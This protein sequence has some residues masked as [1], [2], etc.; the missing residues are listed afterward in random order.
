MLPGEGQAQQGDV[1]TVRLASLSPE[2]EIRMPAAQRWSHVQAL[3]SPCSA[4]SFE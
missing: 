1:V 3:S 4:C 2:K